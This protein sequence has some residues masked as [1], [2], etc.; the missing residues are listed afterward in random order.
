[1]NQS[2]QG[3]DIRLALLSYIEE[4]VHVVYS[5]ALDLYGYG[6]DEFEARSSFAITLEEYLSYTTKENTLLADL[7]RLGWFVDP[8]THTV[9]VPLW[10]SLLTGNEHLT[11]IVTNRPF[12]KFDQPAHIPA[13]A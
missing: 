9:A 5:P 2:D 10:T 6:N 7:R 4:D 8:Q 13:F 12:K 1:M 3:A 11:D